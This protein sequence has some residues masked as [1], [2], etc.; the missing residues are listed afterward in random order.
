[1]DLKHQTVVVTGGSRGLGLGVVEALVERAAQVVVVARNPA[2]LAAVRRRLDVATVAADI[3]DPLAAARVLAERRP[4]V[5]ILNA[6]T[7]PGLGPLHQQTWESFAAPWETDVKAGFHWLQ[8]AL[9][10][11]LSP[12]SR[13]LV[14]SSGAAVAGSPLSGGYAGA[15]RMLWLMANYA[16]GVSLQ[17]N[18]GICVQTIALM[19][20][21]G[22]TGVGQPGAEAY[23]AKLGISPEQF[24]GRF[25]TQLTPREYGE[26]VATLLSDQRYEVARAFALKGDT[27]ITILEGAAA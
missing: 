11:P 13:V 8:A 19:Q 17:Q 20:M 9:K 23:S 2:D 6:G 26:L 5:L 4:A 12:G 21:V 24:L 16:H 18:L 14:T 7:T 25:G 1:M 22:G 15:K 27:G 10:T 3:V